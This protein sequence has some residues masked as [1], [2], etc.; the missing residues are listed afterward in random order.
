MAVEGI[1]VG[2]APTDRFI[3]AS[4]S[5]HLNRTTVFIR[6][7]VVF[8]VEH[9]LLRQRHVVSLMHVVVSWSFCS[10]VRDVV[11]VSRSSSARHFAIYNKS[12]ISLKIFLS[13]AY[14]SY[15]LHECCCSPHK[16]FDSVQ[17]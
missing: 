10:M 4:T 14:V 6:T 7:Q 2:I 1:G 8:V 5:V 17:E 9:L 11:F 3:V 16:N 15:Y 13:I 12:K